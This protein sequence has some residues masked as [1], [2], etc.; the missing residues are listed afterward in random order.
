MTSHELSVYERE[1]AAG[2]ARLADRQLAAKRDRSRRAPKV[3]APSAPNAQRDGTIRARVFERAN[4][5]CELCQA[6]TASEWHHIL[7]GSARTRRE[8]VDTTLALCWECHR[9]WHRGNVDV[10]RDALEV[11]ILRGWKDARDAITRRLEKAE[12]VRAA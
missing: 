10:Y 12:R 4:G 6:R 11:A 1:G 8:A 2:L 7:S 5:I 3:K 9:E